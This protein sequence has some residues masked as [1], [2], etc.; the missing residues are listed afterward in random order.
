MEC[1]GGGH[2][3]VAGSVQAMLQAMSLHLN[4][5]SKAPN[6]ALRWASMVACSMCKILGRASKKMEIPKTTEV[7]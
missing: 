3:Q 2:S 1:R 7:G 5:A 4:G 6:P